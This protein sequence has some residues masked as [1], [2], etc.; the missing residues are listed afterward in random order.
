VLKLIHKKSMNTVTHQV[1]KVACKSVVTMVTMLN[2]RGI[3]V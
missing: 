1:I 2:F 3:N